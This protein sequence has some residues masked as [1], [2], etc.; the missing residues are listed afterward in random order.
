MAAG[1]ERKVVGTDWHAF[2]R[3][4]L[5][6]AAARASP[7]STRAAGNMVVAAAPAM[8]ARRVIVFRTLMERFSAAVIYWPN[9]DKNVLGPQ[10]SLGL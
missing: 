8:K 3:N 10:F 9:S 6:R 1:E 7:T 5:A 4:L 2:A